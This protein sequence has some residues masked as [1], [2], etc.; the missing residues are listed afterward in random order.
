MTPEGHCGGAQG[1]GGG[2]LLG[3]PPNCQIGGIG[4]GVPGAFRAIG[5]DQQR[6]LGAGRRPGCESAPRPELD[7]VGMS[8]DGERGLGCAHLRW[9]SVVQVGME[10]GHG[11]SA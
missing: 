5:H 2:L 8:A 9:Y 1:G 4:I 6:D 10:V 3:G 11:I 7:I